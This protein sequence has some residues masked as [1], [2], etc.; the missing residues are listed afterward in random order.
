VLIT[1]APF[2]TPLSDT[3]RAKEITLLAEVLPLD[4]MPVVAAL[5]ALRLVHVQGKA[6]SALATCLL[7]TGQAELEVL[8]TRT[9]F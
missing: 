7:G 4:L 3:R 5:I 8:V 1:S 2:A 9:L 6:V